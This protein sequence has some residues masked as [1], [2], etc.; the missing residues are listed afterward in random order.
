MGISLN[1][2]G[3]ATSTDTGLTSSH[4]G[5]GTTD[6][7]KD[8]NNCSSTDADK[9]QKELNKSPDESSSGQVQQQAGILCSVSDLYSGTPRT[10]S[11]E[12]EK[13]ATNAEIDQKERARLGNKAYREQVSTNASR[14]THLDAFSRGLSPTGGPPPNAPTQPVPGYNYCG[15]G[16]LNAPP[17]TPLD[18]KC[19]AHDNAYEKANLSHKDVNLLDPGQNNVPGD[20]DRADDELCEF[21]QNNPELISPVVNHLFCD[22]EDYEESQ[23]V[24]WP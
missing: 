4:S 3:S 19:Q 10:T 21:S 22:P 11:A 16:N 8:D 9:F 2:D 13:E 20:Q 6:N 15:P 7:C 23:P 17:T 1:A 12:E 14:V 24:I 18:E 5:S